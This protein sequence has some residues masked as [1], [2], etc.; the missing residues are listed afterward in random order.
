[1]NYLFLRLI[2]KGSYCANAPPRCRCTDERL[3]S[4]NK[5]ALTA[6]Y[7]FLFCKHQKVAKE[8][9]FFCFK[10]FDLRI[11]ALFRTFIWINFK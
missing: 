5:R 1:M 2:L 8:T 11:F 7:C 3:H 6:I 4:P 9:I 10:I